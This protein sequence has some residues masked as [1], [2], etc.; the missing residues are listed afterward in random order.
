MCLVKQGDIAEAVEI[1]LSQA[2]SP[3]LQQEEVVERSM[4]F[5]LLPRDGVSKEWAFLWE[6]EVWVSF[7]SWSWADPSLV[8][9]ELE[10]SVWSLCFSMGFE[11]KTHY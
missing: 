2:S 8:C 6:V 5:Q 11:C 1:G 9:P 7:G 3:L 4:E 10:Q